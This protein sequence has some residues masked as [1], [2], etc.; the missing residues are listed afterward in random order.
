VSLAV[1]LQRLAA[2]SNAREFSETQYLE[3]ARIGGNGVVDRTDVLMPF[4][5]AFKP[6]HSVGICASVR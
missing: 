2:A 1:H 3:P 6:E 5:T 4:G